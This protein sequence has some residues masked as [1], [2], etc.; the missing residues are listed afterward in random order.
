VKKLEYRKA[1]RGDVFHYAIKHVV[2]LDNYEGDARELVDEILLHIDTF[3]ATPDV[4]HNDRSSDW[5]TGEP[6]ELHGERWAT[7]AEVENI[8]AAEAKER[9]RNKI[10]AGKKRE[11][12]FAEFQRLQKKFGMEEMVK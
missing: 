2:P 7:D 1:K 8:K 9:E 4:M 11:K 6:L 5:Y 12:E 10:A 3:I